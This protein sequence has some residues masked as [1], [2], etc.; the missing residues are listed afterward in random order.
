MIKQVDK[1]QEKLLQGLEKRL[2]NVESMI[3][4]T[5]NFI[6]SQPTHIDL[7][8]S[9]LDEVKLEEQSLRARLFNQSML[10]FEAAEDPW[11]KYLVGEVSSNYLDASIIEDERVEK[12]NGW[13]EVR[14]PRVAFEREQ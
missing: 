9:Q 13:C 3:S 5:H 10:N 14:K 4:G 7:I 8:Q 1:Y 11:S 2:G 6:K 12:D